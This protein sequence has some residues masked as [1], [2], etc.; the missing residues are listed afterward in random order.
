MR[1]WKSL[2][3][4]IFGWFWLTLL[5]G[6]MMVFLIT[7]FTGTQPMGRRWLRMTQDL[8]AH[9]AMDF[10]VT[11]GKPALEHYLDTLKRSSAIDAELLD[12]N[13]RD[14]LGR[15]LLS[16]T[17]KVLRESKGDGV[18][19]LS[20]G[21]VWTAATPLL[22][23]GQHYSFVMEVHPMSTFVDGTF[24]YPVLIR[25][26]LALLI[27]ALFCFLLTRH[28]MTPVHAIQRG[29]VR[30]ASGDLR[31]RVLPTISPRSDELADTARAFDQMADRIEL[32]L[33]KQQELLADISHELRS[34]LTRLS[35]SLDIVEGGE[36]DVVPQ[37]RVDLERMNEMIGQILLL[38]RLDLQPA[39]AHLEEVDL[40]HLLVRIAEDAVFEAQAQ[41][42]SVFLEQGDACVIA[43][44]SALLWS[45]LE[46]IVRNAICHT[47]VGTSVEISVHSED[48]PNGFCA[49]TV[50]DSGP[51]V[52]AET[53]RYLCDPFYRVSAAREHNS[54]TGL[55]LSIAK[56]IIDLHGGRIHFRNL[57]AKSG[58]SV[59][60]ELPR[61]HPYT[62]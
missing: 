20:L 5:S 29:A 38:T 51:G 31:T 58:L 60:V 23:D 30:L 15:P 14:V 33:Q 46:N 21:R 45:A 1:V 50:E 27:A 16:D 22:W 4:K 49:I 11:G 48:P 24:A 59:T 40:N 26:V 54:G 39:T 36:T 2:Y 34:P 32:L 56:R 8:Y 19:R 43:G 25:F 28:I 53:L 42:R 55:G 61:A 3:A 18:S 9:S 52:P 41:G 37:M 44:D 17:R 13:D 47:A 57:S 35:I 62:S 10:Y 12:E 6:G 7:T